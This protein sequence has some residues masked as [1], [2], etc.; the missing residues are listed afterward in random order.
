MTSTPTE[1]TPSTRSLAAIW[2]VVVGALAVV[3]VSVLIWLLVDSDSLTSEQSWGAISNESK[4]VTASQELSTTITYEDDSA[5]PE[6][7]AGQRAVVEVDGK[8]EAFVDLGAIEPDDVVVEDGT[9]TVTL[10]PIQYSDPSISNIDWKV[11]DRGLFD[12]VNDFFSSDEDFRNQVIKQL[13]KE[14]ASKAAGSTELEAKAKAN[15]AD[16]LEAILKPAGADRVIVR[17]SDG[18]GVQAPG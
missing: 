18:A 5:L 10:P 2:P 9:V 12:R 4:L 13:N 16:A 15:A 7:L 14:L 3:I 17:F 6:W 11:D 8:V 1:P